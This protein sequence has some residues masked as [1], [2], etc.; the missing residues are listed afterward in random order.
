M[1]VLVPTFLC[2]LAAGIRLPLA[3]TLFVP[4]DRPGIQSAINAAQPGDTVWVA[5]GTYQEWM[6]QMK[7]G[8]RLIAQAEDPALTVIDA[9]GR[10]AVMHCEDLEAD[11]SVEGFT[12]KGGAAQAL[13]PSRAGG[14]RDWESG[15]GMHCK[16]SKLLIRNC[17]FRNNQARF[18]GGLAC[19]WS[20][21]TVE[22]CLFLDNES[23]EQGG[24][25][26]CYDCAPRFLRCRFAG[27][28]A[29]GRGGAL[30]GYRSSVTMEQCEFT[31]NSAGQA[32]EGIG[33]GVSLL[34]SAGAMFSECRFVDNHCGHQGGG[35]GT[36]GGSHTFFS[37]SFEGNSAAEGGGVFLLRNTGSFWDCSFWN[38]SASLGGA[39]MMRLECS[40][41]LLFCSFVENSAGEGGAA[42]A[43]LDLFDQG[44]ASFPYL[45]FCLIVYNTPTEAVL[46]DETGKPSFSCSN[47]FGNAGGDWTGY[48]A[49]QLRTSGNM[50]VDPQL[51][52]VA[53][54]G[55]L[56]LQSDSPCAAANN[57]CGLDIGA[58]PV[59]CDETAARPLSWS[60]LK[61]LFE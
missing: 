23:F 32:G 42:L 40:P 51:C 24:G 41:S 58:H 53:Q 49:D 19:D 9:M 14:D 26:D 1:K 2:L 20:P 7:S 43:V 18:G 57:T 39:M 48:I 34:G 12:L 29:A 22:D 55:N 21:V 28:V 6:I 36:Y 54:S 31:G 10:D 13:P 37:C 52:G 11:T 47:I 35:F 5:P 61:V 38:N 3:G 30:G 27:N 4:G 16:N 45:E 33:G 44:N 50:A 15:G 56:L 46:C 25:V 59:G 8:V 17:I 60:A